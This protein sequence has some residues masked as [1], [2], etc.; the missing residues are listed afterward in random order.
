VERLLLLQK[1]I[2]VKD[3][4]NKKIAIIGTAGI[5]ARYGGF[6][7]L[8]EHL[9]R[10]LGEKFDFTVYCSR[11]NYEQKLSSHNNAQ[12]VYL[13]FG[14]NGK[15][16]VLYD[17]CA[18]FH[19]L[20]YAEA[21]LVLGVSGGL[22]IP[23]VRLLFRGKIIV[24]IDGLEWKRDK[25]RW[26]AKWYLRL[27]EALAVYFSNIIIADH[28]IIQDYVKQ[29]YNKESEYVA[30]GADHVVKRPLSEELLKQYPFLKQPYALS[31]CRIEPENNVHVIMDAMTRL[32]MMNFVVIGNWTASQYARDL[33]DQCLRYK[34]VHMLDSIY[35]Q[36]ILDQFRSN[37]VAYIHGH[38]AGGTNPS[39]V[40]AI[41]LSPPTLAYKV[42]YNQSVAQ[43]AAKYFLTASELYLIAQSMRSETSRE[44]ICQPNNY[45]WG[46]V[47]EAYLRL[48]KN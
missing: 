32:G 24:N 6:E 35:D 22:F 44:L 29:I 42:G 30:Y 47:A 31:V 27:S 38:S 33:K 21:M 9:T 4:R 17:A 25:W 15:Q 12:L 41:A 36:T 39:L 40:E 19:A 2:V 18:M 3:M 10:L 37:C 20:F 46:V 45:Q 1:K 7:T 26:Y 23:L 43:N 34:N 48:I 28:P 5:P 14:S 8:A 11:K 16:S 13:P